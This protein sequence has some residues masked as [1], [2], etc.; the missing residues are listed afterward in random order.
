MSDNPA[1]AVLVRKRAE[2]AGEIERT[3][4]ELKRMIAD[5]DKLDA[6]IRLFDPSVE[7]KA[8]KPKAFRP[9]A[10]WAQRGEMTRVVPDISR[11]TTLPAAVFMTGIRLERLLQAREFQAGSESPSANIVFGFRLLQAVARGAGS[12]RDGPS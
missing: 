6:T 7:V 9:P 11:A 10:D 2:L 8:I 12:R 5:L 3:H 4:A 1:V